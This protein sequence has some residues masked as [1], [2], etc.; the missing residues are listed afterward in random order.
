MN[1][2]TIGGHCDDIEIGMGGTLLVHRDKGDTI[3]NAILFS[4]D[5]K[6]GDP[7]QRIIEQQKAAYVIGANLLLFQYCDSTEKI[8]GELDKIKPDILYF[9]YEVDY[10]QDHRRASEIGFAVSRNVTI[11]VLRY[12][13]VTSYN[14]Y[15]NYL[16][17]INMNEKKK[18]V[19]VYESQI[20]R[21]PK[22]MEMMEAQNK[23]FGSLIPG[24]GLYAEGFIF[25][26]MIAK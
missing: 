3:I 21:R 15:P 4:D 2:L 1:V 19:S 16:Q 17:V 18:L 10:H 26:R 22:Y 24:D 8:V 25:H 20:G 11:D 12:L 7:F 5:A 9:P 13:T 6:A 23:F 14:Y